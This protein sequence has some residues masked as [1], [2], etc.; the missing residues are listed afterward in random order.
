VEW[1]RRSQRHPHEGGQGS[2]D[3][4]PVPGSDFV[5]SGQ[6]PATTA[7]LPATK[8]PSHRHAAPSTTL[9]YWWAQHPGWT[10][11]YSD[12][13][14]LVVSRS[15]VPGGCAARFTCACIW[16][17]NAWQGSP[18]PILPSSR[19]QRPG[20]RRQRKHLVG[21]CRQPAHQSGITQYWVEGGQ[22]Y[23]AESS[24][25][26]SATTTTATCPRAMCGSLPRCL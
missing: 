6:Q 4:D 2:L 14:T 11:V 1:A 22:L 12:A 9:Q 18:S 25:T 5:Y 3:R 21:Q 10:E 7:P 19:Q 23:Q 20:G 17:R 13:H 24:F 26:Q 15:S 16:T 8:S